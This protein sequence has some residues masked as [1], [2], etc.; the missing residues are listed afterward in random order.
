MAETVQATQGNEPEART[1]TGELKDQTGTTPLEDTLKTESSKTE[2][3]E[4]PKTDADGKTLIGKEPAKDEPKQQAPNKYEF[5]QPEGWKEKGWELNPELI[6]KAIPL[7][8]EG[9]LSQEFAQ[10]LVNFYAAQSQADHEAS[11][12]GALEQQKAWRTE[13][14]ADAKLGDGKGLRP[15]VKS[16]IANVIDQ[17]MGP[18]AAKFREAIDFTGA[19]D[20]PDVIRGLL[21]LNERLGEGKQVKGNGPSS[22]GQRTPG[23]PSGAGARA[24]YPTLPS[25][26]GG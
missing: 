3:T 25:A 6:E 2:K 19:G 15:E 18:A 11:V 7:F 17:H 26:T 4:E 9:N 16:A 5:T 10:K 21:A 20:H 1:P 24:M 12:N 22:F 8:K 13:V 23:Q 14:L